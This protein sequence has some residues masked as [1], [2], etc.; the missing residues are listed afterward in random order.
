[1]VWGDR[2]PIAVIEIGRRLA[3]MSGGPLTVLEGVGHYP[4]MEAAEAWA[5]AITR[6][7]DRSV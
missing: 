6:A 3:E 5:T 1:V 2:D 7:L 4:Q